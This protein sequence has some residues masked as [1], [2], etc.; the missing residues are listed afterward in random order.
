MIYAASYS[1]ASVMPYNE[2]IVANAIAS[3]KGKIGAWISHIYVDNPNSVEGGRD[4]W[5]LPKEM[6]DFTWHLGKAP[7]VQVSQGDRVLCSLNC[8]WHLPALPGFQLPV[9]APVL[10]KSGSRFLTFPGQGKLGLQVA[11]ID[12]QIPPESPF[13]PMN[14]GHPWMSFYSNPLVFTAGIPAI[15]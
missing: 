6:A 10:S 12:I 9:G 5:G 14:F 15:I 1:A 13:K 2:L 7:G 8:K 3:Y 4:I 11:G